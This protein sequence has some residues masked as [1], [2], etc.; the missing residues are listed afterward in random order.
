M[1]SMGR[2]ERSA[3]WSVE[4]ERLAHSSMMLSEQETQLQQLECRSTKCYRY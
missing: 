1:S 4:Q 3:E 2:V